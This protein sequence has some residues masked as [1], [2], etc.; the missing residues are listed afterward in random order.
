[1]ALPFKKHFKRGGVGMFHTLNKKISIIL[2]VLAIFYLVLSF[3]LPSYAYVPVD[4]DIVPIGLGILLLILSAILYFAKDQVRKDNDDH[5]PRSE[6]PVIFGVIGFIILYIFFLEIIGFIITT[7]LFLFFCSLFLG[8]KKHVVNAAVSLSI[9]IL[10]Y[11]L[12]DSF[13]QVQLP[14]GILPF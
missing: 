8:F 7:V 1:M 2:V 14:M 12:F 9:P 13:L 3:R 4:A 6:L 10:I 11:L 5:I